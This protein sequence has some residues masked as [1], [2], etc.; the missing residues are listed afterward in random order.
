LDAV[1]AG[2]TAT[3]RRHEG[4]WVHSTTPA[5]LILFDGEPDF[6][7]SGGTPLL[8]AANTTGNVFKSLSDQQTYLL[9]S[10]RWFRALS[11]AG[12]WQFLPADRLPPGFAAIPDDSPKENVKAS[13]PG[14]P[15]LTDALIDNV[16]PEGTKVPRGTRMQDPQ[17]DGPPQLS[18]I[19]GTPLHCVG[20]SGT[21]IIEVGAHS[22]YAC[23]N[24]VWFVRAGAPAGDFTM[25]QAHGVGRG[26]LATIGPGG[27]ALQMHCGD[28]VGANDNRDGHLPVAIGAGND[29]VGAHRQLHPLRCFH[30]GAAVV[31]HHLQPFAFCGE[32]AIVRVVS[33]VKLAV[34]VGALLEGREYL[35]CAGGAGN[36]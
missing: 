33:A 25:R 20:D 32:N 17:I 12:P 7:R 5:E 30:H 21:P 14:T 23:Q 29:A 6:V 16:I 26:K 11:L 18:P 24:G 34:K 35:Q 4:P 28:L 22:W 15:Q 3:R 13:V 9:I 36:G 31:S 8:Y 2:R 1:Y 19:T 10:G 27:A